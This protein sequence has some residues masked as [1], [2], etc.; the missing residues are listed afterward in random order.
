MNT[1]EMA[2]PN[3][4]VSSP[5]ATQKTERTAKAPPPIKALTGIRFLP[6][7]VICWHH[8]RDHWSPMHG[9]FEEVAFKHLVTFF[10]VLSGFILTYRYNYV[11]DVGTSMHFYLAR[12]S[13]LWPMHVFCLTLLLT[14]MPE[15]FMIKNHV[16]EFLCNFFMVQSWVPISKYYFSYNAPS[17]SSATLSFFDIAFPFL[18]IIGQRSKALILAACAAFVAI[19]CY[20]ATAL[21]LPSS[22]V[23][24]ASVHG[25]VY[26]NPFA[27]LLEFATGVAAALSFQTFAHKV[28]L[29]T[30]SATCIELAAIAVLAYINMNCKVW[31]EALQP[32]IGEAGASWIQNSGV[33]FVPFAV[34]I[35][36]LAVEKGL[37]SKLFST[38]WMAV[39]GD[40]S[41]ALY[42]LHAVWIAY[43]NTQF[44]ECYTVAPAFFFF[45][46]LLICA[47][48]MHTSIIKPMRSVIMKYGTQ[49]LELK[50]PSPDPR[51][52]KAK[53]AKPKKSQ[54]K[55]RL[56]LAAEVATA[57]CLFYFGLPTIDRVNQ[58]QAQAMAETA[59][60][61]NVAFD[62]WVKCN[63][64]SA[65]LEKSE[66][67]VVSVWEAAKAESVDF[68]ITS[69]V[70]DK[71]GA[72]LAESRYT[73]DGRRQHVSQGTLW[74]DEIRFAV[75]QGSAPATVA[76]SVT[77]GK[78]R[79]LAPI[80]QDGSK[81]AAGV[82]VVPVAM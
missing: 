31:S 58:Q 64:V 7:I 33:C 78:R 8:A 37:V 5:D 62:P 72:V 17:W 70:L 36:V 16:P 60:V 46:S 49:L 32:Y 65:T 6:L 39:L 53:V 30:V 52:G 34:L 35:T 59:T 3:V 14:T 9:L 10:F 51:H 40:M 38:K 43:F 56:F 74:R 67:K 66:V 22:G 77:R 63:S 26:I 75:P 57:A 25:M 15:F 41:F 23:D 47:H 12:I 18:F 13:R 73:M 24:V 76:L 29:N 81:V 55:K 11:K 69:K 54:L 68:F 2:R 82:V 20:A 19:I 80:G 1:V 61:K 27:R 42:M 71:G 4:A 45:S 44:H 28:K 50:W 48:I 79:A 21:H